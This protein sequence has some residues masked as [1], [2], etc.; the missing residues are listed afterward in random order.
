MGVETVIRLR[1]AQGYYGAGGK[2]VV[3]FSQRHTSFSGTSLPEHL[4]RNMENVLELD[5]KAQNT[6]AIASVAE[7][8]EDLFK[9][10]CRRFQEEYRRFPFR[11][12]IIPRIGFMVYTDTYRGEWV[13]VIT[14][15][16]DRGVLPWLP[17][18][19]YN[20]R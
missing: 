3:T 12:E 20:M 10:D 4:R 19:E 17:D 14:L 2:E 5:A 11:E 18:G 15:R 8:L 7:T 13:Q 9:Q 6:S 1:E 16:N